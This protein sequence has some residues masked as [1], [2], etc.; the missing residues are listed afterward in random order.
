MFLNVLNVSTLSKDRA[1]SNQPL[2]PVTGVVFGSAS[3]CIEI[4]LLETAEN[5]FL[6]TL[7]KH[8]LDMVDLTTSPPNPLLLTFL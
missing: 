2:S 6:I 3:E 1:Y 4:S 8:I 7:F 5:F